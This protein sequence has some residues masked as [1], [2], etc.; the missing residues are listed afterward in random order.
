[1]SYIAYKLYL[2]IIAFLKSRIRL[3]IGTGLSFILKNQSYIEYYYIVHNNC[4]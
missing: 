4:F 3:V 2:I 1:M